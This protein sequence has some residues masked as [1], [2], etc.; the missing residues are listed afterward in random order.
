MSLVG[1]SQRNCR[2]LAIA[3]ADDL[4]CIILVIIIH[5]AD[6][7]LAGRGSI[8]L[9]A[10]VSGYVAHEHQVG[11]DH[12]VLAVGHIDIYLLLSPRQHAVLNVGFHVGTQLRTGTQRCHLGYYLIYMVALQS[13][14]LC[15]ANRYA[16]IE[17]LGLALT[18]LGQRQ[19]HQY[20]GT[21]LHIISPGEGIAI[22]HKSIP[23]ESILSIETVGVSNILFHLCH[24]DMPFATL[25]QNT[26]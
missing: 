6:F 13:S 12:E 8:E 18:V 25:L 22:G 21:L 1:S 7:H 26:G 14:F 4:L 9:D 24:R 2:I 23:I 16:I 19:L 3:L 5:L 11:S 17:E 10:V 20:A 15:G